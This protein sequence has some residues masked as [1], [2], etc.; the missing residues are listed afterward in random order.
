LKEQQWTLDFATMKVDAE[1]RRQ[2]VMVPAT[3]QP[4]VGGRLAQEDLARIE[5]LSSA[6][7]VPHR[8]LAEAKAAHETSPSR[9]SAKT[10][11]T[12]AIWAGRSR[13]PSKGSK[14]WS[15]CP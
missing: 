6:G 8:R 10:F 15:I 12:S 7:A 1:A 9:F 5:R 3:V 11:N 2:V 14:G 13:P 4:R